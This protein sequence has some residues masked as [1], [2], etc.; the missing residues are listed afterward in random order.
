MNKIA[1]RCLSI[2]PALVAVLLCACDKAP[3]VAP[4]AS[5]I[6][7]SSPAGALAPGATTEVTAFVVEEAGT[8]VHNGTIVRFAATMGRVEPAEAETVN[9]VARTTFTAGAA[10]GTARISASS[11]AA[12]AGELGNV[13]EIVIGIT[14]TATVG[15]AVSPSSAAV[16]QPVKLTVTPTIATGG[17]TP[18]VV[19]AWGDGTTTNLGAVASARDVSHIYTAPGTYTITATVTA[20]GT[21]SSSTTVTIGAAAPVTVN[22]G[23]TSA[24]TFARCTPVTLTATATLPTGDTTPIARYDWTIRTNVDSE[25]EDVSTTGNVLVRVFR[26]PGT[27]TVTVQSVTTDGRQGSGQ[28]QFVMRELTATEVCN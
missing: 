9:G 10:S 7:I 21:S 15:L 23:A 8:P 19:V 27:K 22:V 11:G 25:A 3:L 4:V 16:G 14:P 5:T 28:T 20:E 1:T 26:T 24:N 12:V 13:L 18:Q 17:L 6:T 2:A